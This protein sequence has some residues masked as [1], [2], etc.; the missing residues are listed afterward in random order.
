M[1]NSYSRRKFLN[2]LGCGA[3]SSIPFY[4][5]WLSLSQ[6]NAA[7]MAANEDSDD[8]RAI[9]CI[10]LGGGNDSFNM[11]TPRGNGE[12]N[13]YAQTRS[14]LALPQESLLP[15]STTLQ[16][17]VDLGI[18]PSMPEVQALYNEGRLAFISNIGTLIEPT[19]IQKIQSQTAKLP[20]GLFSHSDQ[21]MQWMTS[22]PQ[23]RDALGWGGKMADL[24]SYMNENQTMSMNISLSGNNVFQVGNQT[25]EFTINSESG[26][27]NNIEGYKEED[28]FNQIRTQAINS[29]LEAQYQNI[30][31]QA[32]ANTIKVA[33]NSNELFATALNGVNPL[34]TTFSANPFSR[35]LE[36][37]ARTISARDTLNMKRQVFFLNYGDWDHHDEVIN[38][39]AEM[40]GTLSRGL[41]EFQ[42]ALDELGVADCVTTF[43]ISDFARTLTSNGNGSDHGW[44]GNVFVMGNQVNGGEVYGLYPD[45]GLGNSLD[46]G[47]GVLV[48]TTSTDEYFAEL[49][50]WMGVSPNDLS[51]IF[52]NIGNFYNPAGGSAPIGFLKS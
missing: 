31:Q 17:G 3:M 1:S 11:L 15:L 10:L 21:T 34:E 30:F 19:S 39:H 36:L 23:S 6:M 14:N 20:L 4:A 45:L 41:A 52:P 46:V 18:H 42:M 26:G 28:V 27:A 33:V 40:L 16:T 49:A 50:L 43:S 32:Y 44:G 37:I 22:V 7:A 9:V 51:A 12:Y 29:L 47:D 48:P 2:T 25:I 35:D 5:T 24:I 8:Y 38:I 13:A